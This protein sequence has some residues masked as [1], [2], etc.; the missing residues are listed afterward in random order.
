MISDS[1]PNSSR[2]AGAAVTR[3][4]R[5]GF[6]RC[7][8]LIRKRRYLFT[9]VVIF[10][11]ASGIGGAVWSFVSFRI[12]A[13]LLRNVHP[14]HAA[15]VWTDW[16]EQLR[17]ETDAVRKAVLSSE[18]IRES[19]IAAAL[20]PDVATGESGKAKVAVDELVERIRRSTSVTVSQVDE[21]L[22]VIEI[23]VRDDH[24]SRLR[25]LAAALVAN[26]S[27]QV[28]ASH[29]AKAE[30][31]Y[32]FAK[33]G[34]EDAHHR[35]ETLTAML[36][37]LTRLE[38]VDGEIG[39]FDAQ[40]QSL[41]QYQ[42]EL[43][44]TVEKSKQVTENST[45]T[46]VKQKWDAVVQMELDLANMNL[47]TEER[48]RMKRGIEQLRQHLK[49]SPSEPEP[50]PE[51][52]IDPLPVPDN[53]K[54]AEVES[55]L[56]ACQAGLRERRAEKA[57]LLAALSQSANPELTVLELE[58]SLSKARQV[59][60]DLDA[61]A[62][63]SKAALGVITNQQAVEYSVEGSRVATHAPWQKLAGCIAATV[64]LSLVFGLVVVRLIDG[65]NTTF[66]T[67]TDVQNHL[68]LP[69]L[70]AVP[71]TAVRSAAI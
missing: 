58:Q 19:A 50:M 37:D 20:I 18:N 11:L 36:N 70:G 13:R 6:H 35:V 63:R 59:A 26:Y 64:V 24:P 12:S 68:Q 62:G 54:L 9:L 47:S 25:A 39:E 57:K 48:K 21:S 14:D 5:S 29:K 28:H 65:P 33:Q 30:Q 15:T 55:Q 53:A 49:N 8:E 10:I 2:V 17:L 16:Q 1:R 51:P 23:E 61:K 43:L 46:K 42:E 67:V 52:P 44:A 60:Q 69:I 7:L 71:I 31:A 3:T 27:N 45:A 56:R 38:I 4:P 40:L 66:R 32:G 34:C 22:D 41:S